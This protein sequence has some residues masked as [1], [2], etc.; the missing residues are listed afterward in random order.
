MNMEKLYSL[1][2]YIPPVM[3]LYKFV[4]IIFIKFFNYMLH[5]FVL[6]FNFNSIYEDDSYHHQQ[7][8]LLSR[9]FFTEIMILLYFFT[10]FL[11]IDI[12]LSFLICI[13]FVLEALRYFYIKNIY[14][15]KLLN[16]Y[17]PCIFLIIFSFLLGSDYKFNY[18]TISFFVVSFVF[19]DPRRVILSSVI[20][21][22]PFLLVFSLHF[23][24]VNHVPLY[25][26]HGTFMFIFHYSI[27]FWALFYTV[28]PLKFSYDLYWHQI[29]NLFSINKQLQKSLLDIQRKDDLLDKMSQQ[30]AF[31]S[32]SKGI[33]HEIRNPMASMLLRSEILESDI[34]NE[35]QIKKFLDVVKSEIFRILHITDSMLNYGD[36]ST[37]EY[38]STS[39]SQLIDKTCFMIEGNCKKSNIQLIKDINFHDN[40]SI[41]ANQMTQVFLNLFLNAIDALTSIDRP[42]L[43]I[44]LNSLPESRISL[45]VQDNGVGMDKATLNRIYD[46]FFTTKYENTGLGLSIVLKIIKHH[47]GSI[48]FDSRLGQG[49]T[50]SIILDSV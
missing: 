11:F 23:F 32:L 5:N 29:K 46:P 30:L 6:L 1:N 39:L 26:Y 13:M 45:V 27:I 14:V 4:K 33:A 25:T 16:I 41:D 20:L 35:I 49:T 37:P 34:K 36:I 21:T 43:K 28:V 38:I 7:K 18:F 3:S 24:L 50:V 9:L 17:L 44:S 8:E 22:F 15:S 48:S 10:L 2:F 12:F 47:K 19:F 40:V 31:S 42:I